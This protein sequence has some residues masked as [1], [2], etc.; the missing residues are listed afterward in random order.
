[1]SGTNRQQTTNMDESGC[2]VMKLAREYL[3]KLTI[4]LLLV[5]MALIVAT[6]QPGQV[7]AHHNCNYYGY[8][9]CNY[10]GYYY[11]GYP[12]YYNYYYGG[13]PYYS[14]YYSNYY[15]PSSYTLTVATDPS[16]LGTV[17]GS[18][19]FTSGSSAAFSV[20]QTTV[21]VSPDTR[22][23]FSHWSGDYSGAGSSGTVTVNNAMQIT[24]VYQLQYLLNV[25]AQPQNAPVPQGAG[26]YNAGDT[27]TLQ[28]GGQTIG[29][30][31]SRLNFQGWSVDGQATQPS[32]T[33][34][35]TMNE[36]HSVTALYNQQYY[37]NVQTDQGSAY[38]SGWYDAGST[39]QV[40]ASTP[41]ST[42]YG[43]NIV[44]NGWQGDLQSNNQTASLLMDGPKN[45][46]A[47]W[48]SDPTVLYLT[49]AGLVIAALLIVGGVLVALTRGRSET[50][51]T[52]PPST[53]PATETTSNSQ[54]S[55]TTSQTKSRN[56]NQRYSSV[57]FQ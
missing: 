41:I 3:P 19:S 20:T 7:A 18:G 54:Q 44:F 2:Y 55:A 9:Y 6:A 57:Q 43:V 46:I 30:S 25:N 39:A 4:A 37:L 29:D 50:T 38:G 32:P 23:V 45:V 48:R 28:N 53:P 5:G 14:S 34:Q 33:L 35:V 24:A 11:Y 47:T 31:A 56:G 27:A 16:N 52:L 21:Q 26:W 8:G 10:Y 49:V 1:L 22:Y 12:Y 40:Y 17:T 42:T 51:Q 36:P 15:A 13:Y